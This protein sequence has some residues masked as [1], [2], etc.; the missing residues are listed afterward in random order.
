MAELRRLATAEPSEPHWEE[1]VAALE[2]LPAGDTAAAIDTTL[3]ELRARLATWPPDIPRRLPLRWIF[4][5]P[6]G[7]GRRSALRAKPWHPGVELAT[8]LQ[9]DGQIL[10]SSHG[11]LLRLFEAP[12]LMGLCSLDLGF[13]CA[14]RR[15]WRQ[16]ASRPTRHTL[17]HLALR[18]VGARIAPLLDGPCFAAL[19]HLD[20][21]DGS[22]GAA[23]ISALVRAPHL[24]KL[25]RLDLAR[26]PIGDA[27]LA[28][29]VD[30]G[31][32]SGRLERTALT[33]AGMAQLA[34][35]PRLAAQ[36]VLD[37]SNNRIT[38]AGVAHLM[39]SRGV[40]NVRALD[41]RG[42]AIGPEGAEA[43]A[44]SAHVHRLRSLG[45]H[46]GH[47]GARGL[48]ALT[49]TG[50]FVDI[51]D[52]DLAYCA[53]DDD[54]L[55]GLVRLPSSRL[56]RLDLGSAAI[57]AHGL[58]RLLASPVGSQLEA[59]SLHSCLRLGPKGAAA[60]A[61]APASASLRILNLQ[62]CNLGVQ[63]ARCLAASP[64]LAGLRELW[65]W[66]GDIQRDGERYAWD[67]KA[68]LAAA[69]PHARIIG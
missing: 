43:I 33:D 12:E 30:A 16:I 60:V 65:I 11:E 48:A 59:L 68:E 41:L 69:L 45:L 5:E 17:R 61:E 55:E 51:E 32:V 42:C 47:I 28:A 29:V 49:R 39:A 46:G 15:Q 38:A 56:R 21:S 9:L 25:A 67:I 10:T 35:S 34:R 62:N 4:A 57:T 8:H 53:I 63:G 54:A 19:E 1:L 44:A 50:W 6:M 66:T 52:L 20:L 31:V 64:F 3:D 2:L 26:N 7:G 14:S 36:G 58:Q 24:T 37:L 23:E 18:G 22:L 13:A 40:E 27:G